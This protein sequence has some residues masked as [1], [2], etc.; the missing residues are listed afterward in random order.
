MLI[1]QSF[2]KFQDYEVVMELNELSASKLDGHHISCSS[3]ITFVYN[4]KKAMSE[5]SV[6]WKHLLTEDVKK[7]RIRYDE[8]LAAHE[9]K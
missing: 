6:K 3:N 5:F 8:L 1:K 7:L 2:Y 4:K 9:E